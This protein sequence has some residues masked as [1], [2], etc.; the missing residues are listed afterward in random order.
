MH[1][2]DIGVLLG[3]VSRAEI[4]HY[5]KDPLKAQKKVL[6]KIIRRNKNCELGKKLNLK[7]VKSIEDYQ[8]IVPLSTY[9]DYEPYVDRMINNGEDRIM[10]SGK[11]LHYA[12][13]SGS[14]GKP[15]ILPKGLN[16]LWKMQCLG[17]S[18]T[19]ATAYHHMKERGI[20]MSNQVG[21][22]AL[23]LSGHKLK[24]GKQ[25]NGAGQIPLRFLRTL[26]PFFC[27]SPMSLLYPSLEDKLDTSY[28]HLRFCLENKKV[29]YL[30]SIVVTLLTTMFDYLEE[31]WEMM[32]D[33]IEK[34]IINPNID[35]PDNLRKKY[36]KKFKPNPERANELRAIFKEGFDEPVAPKIWPG[37]QWAYGMMGSNLS[38]YVE[39]LRKV[40]GPNVP[41]HNMGY[42]A[43]E[44]FFAAPTELDV[45]DYVLLP[46]CLFFEFLPIE[47]LEDSADDTVKPL[48][49]NELEVG[50]NY[51]MVVSNFSGLY[52]YKIEDVVHVTR[53]YNNTPEIEL[54]FRQN[55]SMNVANEKTTTD[56]I[57][58]AVQNSVKEMGVEYR[59]FSFYPDFST[60]PPRYTLLIELKGGALDE[61]GRQKFIDTIDHQFDEINEKYY[62][63]RRWGMLN[64]PE[65]LF[66]EE[67]TYVG[68]ND[69][70]AA[71]GVVLNQIKPVTVINSA[72]RKDYFLSHVINKDSSAVTEWLE[73]KES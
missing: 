25:C 68:Y 15:K 29:S 6:K 14:V 44:G 66:L 35:I 54:L 10:F 67:K 22:L 73:S 49:I 17:F 52:R 61:E 18:V 26:M 12:S 27:T 55:L 56:M 23:N 59:G 38:V 24:D 69:M 8:R 41:I 37:L 28:L 16:D 64:R 60:K 53:M 11:N 5:T 20:R 57:D 46:W 62:K 65:V 58:A 33:D 13:S 48:L 50:K 40:I 47:D 4:K 70:L 2:S 71:K 42:A 72:E 9:A 43:A 7:D 39:K 36:A 3:D 63:Y 21:P 34:G 45:N 30:G 1:F 51:E 32:C 31:N 19:I